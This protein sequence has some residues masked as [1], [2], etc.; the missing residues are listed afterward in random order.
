MSKKDEQTATADL[1]A[2]T[3]YPDAQA[4]FSSPQ[5]GLDA[6]KD[7]C[8]VVLDTNVLLVPFDVGKDSLE[9]LRRTY[10]NLVKQKRLVVPGHVAREFARNRAS[11]L[12]ALYQSLSQKKNLPQL[13]KRD[14][15]AA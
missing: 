3:V 2:R 14:V 4:I 5:L 9:Q 13:Q 11:K 8:C 15:S 7:D 1:T 12:V 10:Q 6:I